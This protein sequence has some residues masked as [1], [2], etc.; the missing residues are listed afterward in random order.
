[1]GP[2]PIRPSS[3]DLER[4]RLE[5]TI[6]HDLHSLSLSSLLSTTPS[7]SSIPPPPTTNFDWAQG[8]KGRY[9][10]VRV[11]PESERERQQQQQQASAR[12]TQNHRQQQRSLDHQMSTTFCSISSIEQ[13]RGET[14]AHPSFHG[15]ANHNDMTFDQYLDRTYE[16][17]G[18]NDMS[19]DNH[20]HHHDQGGFGAETE[21]RDR[22]LGLGPHGT[23]RAGARKVSGMSE[24]SMAESPVSTAGHHVSAVTLGDGVFRRPIA[25]GPSGGSGSGNRDVQGGQENEW[26]PER[27]FGRLVGE[28]GKVMNGVSACLHPPKHFFPANRLRTIMTAQQP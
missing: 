16:V 22:Y 4:R 2:A 27:S 21:A 10:E 24:R 11:R 23:P 8:G 18:D 15:H 9:P 19:D 7:S 3:T 13:A 6:D 17:N 12:S 28:L 25:R 14:A 1:M 26:D 20:Q 5:S